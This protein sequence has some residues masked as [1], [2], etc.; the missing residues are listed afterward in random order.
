[1]IGSTNDGDAP[2]ANHNIFEGENHRGADDGVDFSKLQLY[3]YVPDET[4]LKFFS[5]TSAL[6]LYAVL[7]EF[8]EKIGTEPKCSKDT[9]KAKF[10]KEV[11]NKVVKVS[12]MIT[13]VEAGKHSVEFTKKEGDFFE[14]HN[15]YK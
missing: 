7:L 2:E 11:N 4:H 5:T 15:L 14:Y 9:F 12:F 13:E 8:C 3:K 1:M 6:D 10:T